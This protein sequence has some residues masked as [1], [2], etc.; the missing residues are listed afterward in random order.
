MNLKDILYC[1]LSNQCNYEGSKRRRFN[2]SFVKFEYDFKLVIRK[3]LMD[4]LSNMSKVRY[5]FSATLSLGIFRGLK[6]FLAI[7]DKG[8]DFLS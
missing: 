1:I 3:C 8:V 2:I 6:L 7:Q 5:K 4:I